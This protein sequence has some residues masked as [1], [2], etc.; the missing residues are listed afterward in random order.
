M[1]IVHVTDSHLAPVG[2]RFRREGFEDALFAKLEQ[3]VSIAS[4]LKAP[5][6][7]TGDMF[8]LQNPRGVPR[9]LIG[10]V[11]DLL[12]SGPPWYLLTG[13]HDLQGRD[14][15][16][17][18]RCPMALLRHHPAVR[19]I[20]EQGAQVELDSGHT[21]LL[22]PYSH[23]V[24]QI[25]EQLTHLPGR[26]KPH[27]IAVHAMVVPAPV[28]WEHVTLTT[29]AGVAPV[30][31]SGD[32]HPGYPPI[33]VGETLFS[34]PGALARVDRSE[35]ERVPQVSIVDLEAHSAEYIE[36]DHL[37]P[38]EAFDLEAAEAQVEQEAR[39]SQFAQRLS[40]LGLDTAL[41]WD[42]LSKHLPEEDADVIDTARGYYE[43][44]LES[45]AT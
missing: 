16:S 3:V 26:E 40:G 38:G 45:A 35:A 36:L 34:N 19:V 14:P 29:L 30:V 4:D 24:Y 43:R 13:Q 21:V 42:E 31:V 9:E 10:R 44:A 18:P 23:R 28:P 32:Y 37:G 6:I 1:K 41:S 7:H 2:T 20:A 27:I 15:S 5:I 12:A 25:L 11:H 17:F 8:D 39:R 22:L 33:T